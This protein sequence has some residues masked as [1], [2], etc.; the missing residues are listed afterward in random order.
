MSVVSRTAYLGSFLSQSNLCFSEEWSSLAYLH[1]KVP[2]SKL[3]AEGCES[4]PD[5]LLCESLE[6]IARIEWLLCKYVTMG[7]GSDSVSFI[8][9]DVS[10]QARMLV[11]LMANF[12]RV[13]PS[14]WFVFPANVDD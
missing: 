8:I 11:V 13:N 4:S 14:S 10:V 1:R 7:C 9:K 12:L 3:W 5:G 2:T 6:R